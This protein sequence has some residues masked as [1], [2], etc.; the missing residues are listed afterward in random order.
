MGSSSGSAAG[1]AA[2]D[3]LDVTIGSDT[4]GSSRRPAFVNG[5]FQIRISQEKLPLDGLLPCFPFFDAIAV[6]MRSI[7][8]L[9][10]FTKAWFAGPE[11]SHTNKL[12]QQNTPKPTRIVFPSDYLPVK[13]PEQMLLINKAI[14]DMTNCFGGIPIETVSFEGLWTTTT[15]PEAAGLSLKE[16]LKDV[17]ALIP[18]NWSR[19]IFTRL[20]LM[21]FCTI[22]TT[23]MTNSANHIAQRLGKSPS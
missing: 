6:F 18:E 21:D 5:C 4:T 3:W 17:R 12:A 20:A 9:C 23:V 16:Y 2:Y 19:L 15:P 11:R 13:D 22:S 14:D 10:S 1:I 8:G 7:D